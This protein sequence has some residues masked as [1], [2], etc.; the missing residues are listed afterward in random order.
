M[1]LD[2]D[3]QGRVER[4]AED[5]ACP[6]DGFGLIHGPIVAAGR[7]SPRSPL[8]VTATVIMG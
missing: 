6:A 1:C 4:A 7:G 5:A 8:N 2:R 3:R